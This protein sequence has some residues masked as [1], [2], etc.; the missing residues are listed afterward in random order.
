MNLRDMA[1]LGEMIRNEG[2][3]NH[4]QVIPKKA[5]KEL[6]EAEN[7]DAE[8]NKISAIYST[9][10]NLLNDKN[11][12][13]KYSAEIGLFEKLYSMNDIN[14]ICPTKD[15]FLLIPYR[16]TEED[17]VMIIKTDIFPSAT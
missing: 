11:M 14:G 9:I 6:E 2:Y 10:Y 13:E 5:A 17:T 1:L 7:P 12:A 15:G 3:I 16:P 4:K 8:A